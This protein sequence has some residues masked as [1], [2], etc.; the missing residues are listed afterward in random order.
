[1]SEFKLRAAKSGIFDESINLYGWQIKGRERYV[2]KHPELVPMAEHASPEAFLSLEPTQ[3]QYLIDSLW[4]C[5]LRPSEGSGSAGALLATQKHLG[6]MKTIAFHS[7]K[8]RK[9]E[10]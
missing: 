3:A 9:E 1:M 2:I 6:D 5:G 10:K 4:D 8:I 7:L